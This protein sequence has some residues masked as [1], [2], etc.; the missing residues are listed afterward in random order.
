MLLNLIEMRLNTCQL[1]IVQ[2]QQHDLNFLSLLLL[3]RK[4]RIRLERNS[5][6]LEFILLLLRIFL[7]YHNLAV[8]LR[9]YS[10]SEYLIVDN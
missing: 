3:S 9:F 4:H 7:K 5:I 6:K 10:H 2:I 8:A 1:L